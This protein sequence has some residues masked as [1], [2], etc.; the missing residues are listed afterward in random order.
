MSIIAPPPDLGAA[1]DVRR[2]ATVVAEVSDDERRS[3]IRPLATSP[4]A[5]KPLRMRR[6]M[7]ASA[8]CTPVRS[9]TTQSS[10]AS[11]ADQRDWLFAQHVLARSAA[12]IDHGTC[13]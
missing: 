13:R 12:R 7:K 4:C 6:T 10:R 5:R 2:V 11:L 1:S 3:P 8:I 9:R